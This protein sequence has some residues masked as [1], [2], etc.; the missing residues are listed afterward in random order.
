VFHKDLRY[1]IH[2]HTQSY[3]IYDDD[4]DDDD[5]DDEQW[6]R[7]WIGTYRKPPF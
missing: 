2:L 1:A 4:D 3:I 5:D 7:P 6:V